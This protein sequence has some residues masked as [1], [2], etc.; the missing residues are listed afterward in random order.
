MLSKGS[1]SIKTAADLQKIHGYRYDIDPKRDP[2]KRILQYY[3][4]TPETQC[5]LSICHKWHNDGYLVE[6]ENGSLTNVGHICGA[7]FGAKFEAERIHYMD[8]IY[9]PQALRAVRYGIMLLESKQAQ[10]N[11]LADTANRLSSRKS[12]FRIRFPEASKNLD[13]R[14]STGNLMVTDSFERTRD[15]IEAILATNPYQNRESLRFR[16]IEK[17]RIAGLQLFSFNIRESI[18][19]ELVSKAQELI[20]LSIDAQNL[21]TEVLGQWESWLNSFN[22]RL[23][24]AMNFV[25]KAEGFFS[26]ENY[27]LIASFSLPPK[28][29]FMLKQLKT[30]SLDDAMSV[31]ERENAIDTTIR[32]KKLSRAERRKLQ[33]NST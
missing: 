8:T 4:V 9:R 16:E 33:F 2:L 24:D 25:N 7:G 11:A 5:G 14:A 22:E 30:A 29:S 12:E 31:N 15:E 6:L 27:Q 19:Q 17:G 3:H 21:K 28:E 10:I 26:E 20:A 32:N 23:D 1:Y 18:S 13:R